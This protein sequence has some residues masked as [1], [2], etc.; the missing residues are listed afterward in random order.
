MM[1][2]YSTPPSPRLHSPLALVVA[3]PSTPSPRR[4]RFMKLL[5]RIMNGVTDS[6]WTRCL[7]TGLCLP[8]SFGLVNNPY[9]IMIRLFFLL[10]LFHAQVENVRTTLKVSQLDTH[11]NCLA[12]IILTHCLARC[13]EIIINCSTNQ[14]SELRKDR[15]NTTL[16]LKPSGGL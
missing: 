1:I 2:A 6:S 14:R 16:F 11:Q 13:I 15:H 5:A 10:S 3:S 12:E 7:R 4:K 9:V 8:P